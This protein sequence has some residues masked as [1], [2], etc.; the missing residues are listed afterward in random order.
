M[1]QQAEVL[2][3]DI[4][5]LLP[6]TTKCLFTL[7]SR[8][9]SAALSDKRSTLAFVRADHDALDHGRD[10]TKQSEGQCASDQRTVESDW[11]RAVP[12]SPASRTVAPRDWPALTFEQQGTYQEVMNATASM[13]CAWLS[14]PFKSVP[15]S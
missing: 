6:K 2:A 7:L 14:R 8:V 9:C 10:L 12:A 4:V 1:A 3:L 13:V 15:A 11:S 5:L